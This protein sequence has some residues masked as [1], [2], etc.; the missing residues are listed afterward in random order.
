MSVEEIDVSQLKTL[1]E[2]SKELVAHKDELHRKSKVKR[3]LIAEKKDVVAPLNEMIKNV[4]EEIQ[5]ELELLDELNSRS[6]EIQ[7]SALLAE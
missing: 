1:A 5:F 6:L 2:V 3:D 4:E 7:A